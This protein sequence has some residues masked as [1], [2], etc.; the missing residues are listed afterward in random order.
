MSKKRENT[1]ALIGR[2]YDAEVANLRGER[3]IRRVMGKHVMMRFDGR[4]ITELDG[5]TLARLFPGKNDQPILRMTAPNVLSLRSHRVL[6]RAIE[7]RGGKVLNMPE[8]VIGAADIVES[9]VE[10]VSTSDSTAWLRAHPQL[11]RAEVHN[12]WG[13][14]RE[15]NRLAYFLSAY[16]TAE[17]G[18]TYFFC[19]LP[20]DAAPTTIGQAYEALKP[21]SVRQAEVQKIKVRRQGDMFFIRQTR[22]HPKEDEFDAPTYLHN[23][24][25]LGTHVVRQDGLTYVRG[26]VRHAPIGRKPDH[27]KLHLGQTW[28][29][30]VKNTVPVTR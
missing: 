26:Q 11:I 1:D 24:N 10:I 28:W 22:W 7:K 25:H 23:T 18:L 14:W 4:T 30:C 29:L 20:P 21:E 19:E 15:P 13:S 5:T 6:K 9:T 8:N 17:P 16:D 27:R 2:W 12:R 3:G